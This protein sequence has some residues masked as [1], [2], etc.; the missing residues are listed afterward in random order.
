MVALTEGFTQNHAR[1]DRNIHRANLRSHGQPD[2]P[3]RLLCH[4]RAHAVTLRAQD[5]HGG[6]LEINITQVKRK[7]KK[8]EQ[9]FFKL[10]IEN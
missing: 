1:A 3:I 7:L 10:E 2:A 5:D 8:N 6:L 4:T 9:K